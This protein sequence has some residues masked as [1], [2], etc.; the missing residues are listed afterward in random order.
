MTAHAFVGRERE[1]DRLQQSL[2]L[3]LDGQGQVCLVIGEAGSGKT[4]LVTELARRAERIN[5]DLVVAFGTCN[6]HS[7]IGDPYLPFR[8]ILSLLTGD[9]QTGLAMGA[10]S[11]ENAIR[12]RKA[13]AISAELLVNLGPDLIGVFLPGAGL[14][15]RAATFVAEQAGWMARMEKLAKRRGAPPAEATELQQSHIF[16]Q[17]TRVVNALAAERPLMLVLDDLHWADASSISLLFHLGRRIGDSRILMLGTCRPEEVA[18]GRDGKRHPL[19]QVIN[20]FKRYF[21]DICVD[22]DQAGEAE[23]RRFVDAF[24]DS[25]PNRLSYSFRQALLRH[26]GGHPLFTVELLRYMQDQAQLIKDAQGRWVETPALDWETLPPRVEGVIEERFGRLQEELR[27]TSTVASVEG[28]E[29]SVQVLA[30]VRQTGARTIVRQLGDELD[31]KHRLVAE[32]GSRQVGQKRLHLY[33]FCHGLF[34]RHL[35]NSLRHIEREL[36]HQDVARALEELYGGLAEQIASQLAWHFT[37]AGDRQKAINY[38][39]LAGEQAASRYANTEAILDFTR[40]L[41]LVSEDALADRFALLLAR[42]R[43]YDLQGARDLQR[44]DLETLD[45]LANSLADKHRQASVALRWAHY[46]EVTGDLQ[47][48]LAA[49]QKAVDLAQDV[50]DASSEAEGYLL[51][52]RTLWRQGHSGLARKRLEQALVVTRSMHLRR[53]Q[54]QCLRNLGIVSDVQ[55]DSVAS[56]S[57]L[58][59]ALS[60]FQE[61]GSRQ[62]VGVTLNS[63]GVVSD[64]QGDYGRAR[65]C[66][67]QALRIYHEIGDRRNEGITVSNLGAISQ[68]LGDYS[69]ASTD[70]EHALRISR[71]VDDKAGELGTLVNLGLVYHNLGDDEAASEHCHQAL[72]IAQQLGERHDQAYAWTFLGH[73]LT[74]LGRLDE[75][76]DAY[77]RAVELRRELGQSNLRMEALAGAARVSI[78]LGDGA[79]ALA[80]AEKILDHLERN[81]LDGTEEPFLVYL[82]CYRILRANQDPRAVAVLDEAHSLLQERASRIEGEDMRREFLEHVQAHRDLIREW[83]QCT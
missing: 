82:T 61:M 44:Q 35:Y 12:L 16:E 13:L 30:A 75:A 46:A 40:G 33:R 49:A 3:V 27:E 14:A 62:G 29:F 22:L 48:A 6:A 23:V 11:R 56:R 20:E 77:G 54:A 5:S 53:L 34:Q 1:L 24:L 68:N 17:Y 10:I 80:Q 70:L 38:L 66:F 19:E 28:E 83:Q 64:H 7:G 72:I 65:I 32:Q 39:T 67:E 18:L 15:A 78:A 71:D 26:T 55:G 57:Y 41:R 73:A 47:K 4:A 43:V 8:E 36:L 51:W 60:I 76:A 2:D 21:G 79:T 42:E 59:Q 63:L 58:E 37:E 69:R 74:S 31:R 50:E 52:G 45:E 81:T 9:V 25:E